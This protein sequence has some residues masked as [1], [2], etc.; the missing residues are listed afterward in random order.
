MKKLYRHGDLCIK[1]IKEIPKTAKK[2]NTLTL[3]L[4][5][6]TGHHHT[7]VKERENLIEVF[8]DEGG[9]YFKVGQ[10]TPLIHQEHKTITIEKGIYFIEIEQ[11]RDPF[12]E[13]INKVK[14]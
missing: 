6:A 12:T 4:G 7:L 13:Q 3:A 1:P 14:D 8:E 11:E 5:E 9:K 10:P 2:L